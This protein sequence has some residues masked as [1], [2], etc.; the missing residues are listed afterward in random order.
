MDK[1]REILSEIDKEAND[2]EMVAVFNKLSKYIGPKPTTAMTCSLV[3]N[4]KEVLQEN[5]NNDVPI[6]KPVD[7]LAVR[8]TVGDGGLLSVFRLVKPQINILNWRFMALT[9]LIIFVG[10]VLTKG[11]A[12]SLI[13]LTN[14]A[15]IL[16]LL[17]LFCEHRAA[18]YDTSE[19][20]ASCPYTPAQLAGARIIVTLGYTIIV[21]LTATGIISFSFSEMLTKEK[22]LLWKA[23]LDWLAPMVFLLG[24]ALASS[25]RFGIISGCS[26]AFVM[27]AAQI[28]FEQSDA[29]NRFIQASL[30]HEMP[31]VFLLLGLMLIAIYIRYLHIE[32]IDYSQE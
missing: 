29:G 18:L 12:D 20:E 32:N 31:M 5:A 15:P 8:R 11:N 13:F 6:I 3:D 26:C 4:L 9:S 7:R 22:I 25:L 10:I 19:L 24:V 23:I 27:W 30:W 14:V 21:C 17:T 1:Y 2:K 28:I 16:G